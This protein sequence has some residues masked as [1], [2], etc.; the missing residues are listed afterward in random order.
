MNLKDRGITIGDLLLTIIFI[1]ST[2]FIV[3]KIKTSNNQSFLNVIPYQYQ[4][5]KVN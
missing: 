1:I 5:T 2:I 3:N 4:T